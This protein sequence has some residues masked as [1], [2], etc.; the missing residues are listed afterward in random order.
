MADVVNI[1]PN[2]NIAVPVPQQSPGPDWAQDIYNALFSKIDAHDHSPN[3]GVVITPS[4]LNINSPLTFGSNNATNML[5]AGFTSQASP[6]AIAT[7]PAAVY[8]SGGNL[9]YNSS[10]TQIQLT[11]PTGVNATSS[12]I[13]SG[14]ATASFVSSVLVVN[15]AANT[16]ANIQAGSYLLGNNTA[17]S[18]FIT[19]APATTIPAN[20]TLSLPVAP[21]SST[22]VLEMNPSGTISPISGG[23]PNSLLA[24]YNIVVSG[25]T[26]SNSVTS[27]SYVEV[28]SEA[29]TT[30]GRPVRISIQSDGSANASAFILVNNSGS[31]GVYSFNWEL[32]TGPSFSGSSQIA[33]GQVSSYIPAAV[34]ASVFLLPSVGFTTTSFASGSNIVYFAIKCNFSNTEFITSF[35][36]L[37]LEEL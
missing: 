37:V 23:V 3:N 26:G 6:L 29:I 8:V 9:Y 11:T 21:P 20:Y 25:S 10:S 36:S 30:V 15:E 18:D 5:A 19:I 33:V 27:L 31:A 17:G 28:N 7:Y 24:P 12:G 13:S 16:P 2:M 35:T 1:S 34:G 32:T 4:G 22:S 14:T